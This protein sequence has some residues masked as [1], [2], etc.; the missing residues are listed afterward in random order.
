MRRPIKQEAISRR[1][2][3]QRESSS[4]PTGFESQ[5]AF[6]IRGFA[7]NPVARIEFQKSRDFSR[8]EAGLDADGH[9]VARHLSGKRG[10]ER[11]HRQRP[12]ASK[13]FAKIK[14]VE[15]GETISQLG[16]LGLCEMMEDERADAG[17]ALESGE[18]FEKIALFPIDAVVQ[19]P[20]ALDQIEAGHRQI[21]TQAVESSEESSLPAS[22]FNDRGSFRDLADATGHPSRVT[23]EG[24]N[25]PQ[26]LPTSAS[27][28][29]GRRKGVED[30]SR[31]NP[32]HWS[33]AIGLGASSG[34]A[35]M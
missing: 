35:A 30:F 22:D 1:E 26:I 10:G 24:V 14:P 21:G 19:I 29:I 5:G 16:K 32:E 4:D 31:Y 3:R 27:T 11:R 12:S 17:P 20:G 15:M 8:L 18:G 6:P 23:H 7:E 9:V 34:Q 33:H 2:V 13:G 25:D 28:G